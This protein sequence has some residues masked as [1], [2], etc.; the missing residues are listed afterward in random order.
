MSVVTFH[1]EINRCCFFQGNKCSTWRGLEVV[2]HR[3]PGAIFSTSKTFSRRTKENISGL[4]EKKADSYDNNKRGSRNLSFGSQWG[5]T[6][7]HAPLNVGHKTGPD[8][9]QRKFSSKLNIDV[10]IDKNA[11]RTLS[12]KEKILEVLLSQHQAMRVQ[13]HV[14]RDI[15][16]LVQHCVD[17]AL[18]CDNQTLEDSA[19]CSKIQVKKN[20]LESL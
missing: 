16:L 20:N 6:P 17:D 8:G 10:K 1:Y 11:F 3:G 9:C 18:C 5:S 2:T 19:C 12:E 15:V 7:L 13:M 4:L 14:A